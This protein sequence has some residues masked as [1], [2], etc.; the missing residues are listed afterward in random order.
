MN[1]TISQFN[2]EFPDDEACLERMFQK[3]FGDLKYCP[4]CAFE[5]SFYKISDRKCYSC[6]HC[7][8][9]I[10]PLAGTI[11]HKS[12]T[13]LKLWFYAIFLFSSSK[14]GVSA[15]ELQRQLGVTYKTAWRMA[16]Q[17]RQLFDESGSSDL[18]GTVEM[19]ETYIGGRRPMAQKMDNKTPV[20]GAVE[21]GDRIKSVVTQDD[22]QQPYSA[23]S[24]TTCPRRYFVYG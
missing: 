6:K 12:P 3:R 11:F 1:Y 2:K 19:D 4:K 17:I 9:H 8:H 22:Q 7:G 13:P 16:K 5:T 14:N 20:I 21:R 18:G 23:L 10:Y 15:K 24:V